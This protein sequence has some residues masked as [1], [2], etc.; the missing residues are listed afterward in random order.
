MG[1]NTKLVAS[2]REAST[3]L[4]AIYAKKNSNSIVNKFKQIY[5][6]NNSKI[7]EANLPG[8]L[9]QQVVFSTAG[10][11]QVPYPQAWP[12]TYHAE[13]TK[14][15]IKASG[16]DRELTQAQD[17][18]NKSGICVPLP[19]ANSNSPDRLAISKKNIAQ[20][21]VKCAK[22]VEVTDIE[23]GKTVTYESQRQAAKEL[24]TN[25]TTIRNY[26]KKHKV[27]RPFDSLGGLIPS[28]YKIE[29]KG[30]VVSIRENNLSQVKHFPSAIREWGNSIFTN[31]PHLV[32]LA[33]IDKMIIKIIRSYFNSKNKLQKNDRQLGVKEKVYLSKVE[34]KHTSSKVIITVYIYATLYKQLD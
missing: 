19:L 25:Q 18:I 30:Q 9:N 33:A 21:N 12:A 17:H 34:V 10:D 6:L 7:I 1:K 16:A 14:D 31:Y 3:F 29:V 11:G 5:D 23:T 4:Y 27:Y 20:Y 15:Q 8:E 22:V 2:L 28:K 13:T 24:N 32:G 26:I